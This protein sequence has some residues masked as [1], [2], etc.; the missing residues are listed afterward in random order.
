M[1]PSSVRPLEGGGMGTSMAYSF[2]GTSMSSLAHNNPTT[3]MGSR[4]GPKLLLSSDPMPS[5]PQER[6]DNTA[7]KGAKALLLDGLTHLMQ[8]KGP[9]E[10]VTPRKRRPRA[11]S[12]DSVTDFLASFVPLGCSEM[13][14]M[15]ALYPPRNKHQNS[16]ISR[17]GDRTP[18]PL[19]SLHSP[20]MNINEHRVGGF[21]MSLMT[22]LHATLSPATSFISTPMAHPSVGKKQPRFP[23]ATTTSFRMPSMDRQS[24]VQAVIAPPIANCEDPLSP[25]RSGFG[26]SWMGQPH[27]IASPKFNLPKSRKNSAF[28]F[29][30]EESFLIHLQAADD[31]PQGI[32]GGN[33]NTA[34]TGASKYQVQG[35]DGL[36]G[37]VQGESSGSPASATRTIV[38][39]NF[40]AEATGVPPPLDAEDTS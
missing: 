3:L 32:T 10:A 7:T 36:V 22:P 24:S 20:P 8:Q 35:R 26:E 11:L 6:G 34:N 13:S 33:S 15:G 17:R 37:L 38:P 18:S 40:V 29:N 31:S 19:A 2:H 9:S 25:P 27:T 28:G 12:I 30:A 14:G 23:I 1:S 16:N 21:E 39:S 4:G 5:T